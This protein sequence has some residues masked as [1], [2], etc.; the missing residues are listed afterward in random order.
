MSERAGI[1]FTRDQI[2]AWAGFTLTDEQ[3]TD[4]ENILPNSTFPETVALVAES[5]ES[6]A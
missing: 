2:E 3:V 4:L 6:D 1:S 5:M